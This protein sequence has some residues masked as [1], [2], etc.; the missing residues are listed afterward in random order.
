MSGELEHYASKKHIF[1]AKQEDTAF[2]FYDNK[3][4]KHNG[5]PDDYILYETKYDNGEVITTK[6]VISKEDF[7]DNYINIQ[8]I[9]RQGHEIDNSGIELFR[10]MGAAMM[11]EIDKKMKKDTEDTSLILAKNLMTGMMNAFEKGEG[12]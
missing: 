12:K 6:V 8:K 1:L 9:F 5:N 3:A 10:N 11:K 7:E 2:F 4:K